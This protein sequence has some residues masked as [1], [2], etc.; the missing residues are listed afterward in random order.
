MTQLDFLIHYLQLYK[1]DIIFDNQ[2]DLIIEF[3]DLNEINKKLP[4]ELIG[5]EFFDY[6]ITYY[7][8]SFNSLE[9]FQEEIQVSYQ[10]MVDF[11][12]GKIRV[13][14][15]KKLLKNYFNQNLPV[16][17]EVFY[18]L[19]NFIANIKSIENSSNESTNKKIIFVIEKLNERFY[20]NEYLIIVNLIELSH[21]D[22]KPILQESIEKFKTIQEIYDYKD[23]NHYQQVPYFWH[24]SNQSGDLKPLKKECV[25][26]FFYLISNKV[27]D[28]SEIYIIKGH[29]NLEFKLHINSYDFDTNPFLRILNFTLDKEKHYD[30]LLIIR[31]VFTTYVNNFSSFSQVSQQINEIVAT[32]E[33]HYEL[34]IQNEMKIFI[35]QKNQ[36]LNET[37][38]LAKQVSNLTVEIGSNLRNLLL[39]LFAAIVVSVIPQY[40][41]NS[42]NENIILLLTFSY[43]L[44]LIFNFYISFK[45]K[46]Q[47]DNYLENFKNYTRYISS[48]SL[49]GLDYQ[50][51]KNSFINKEEVD[52][53]DILMIYRLVIYALIIISICL[54]L[55]LVESL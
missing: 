31:N 29:H 26:T 25:K 17:T 40:T 53:Y 20:E 32:I 45:I 47:L 49:A 24:F 16:N 12:E 41:E 22:M 54:I 50:S 4:S 21:Q 43:L 46:S 38:S 34:Y 48:Q 3:K 39:T 6:T 9:E 14:I 55:Y 11:E 33:H 35:E 28:G 2:K 23:V 7:V 51:L 52:F 27:K 19:E 37:L 18:N 36:V 8:E 44:Y 30:K 42:N 13:V 15:N 1:E 10:G 5:L